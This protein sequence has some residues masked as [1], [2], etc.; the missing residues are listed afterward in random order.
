LELEIIKRNQSIGNLT[1]RTRT[2]ETPKRY[3]GR[4][5]NSRDIVERYLNSS[6]TLFNNSTVMTRIN[7]TIKD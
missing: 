4:S 6:G 7:K 3:Q 5:R 2:S 1:Q